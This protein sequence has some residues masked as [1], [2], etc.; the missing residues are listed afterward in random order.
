MRESYGGHIRKSLI[1][2]GVNGRLLPPSSGP[3]ILLTYVYAGGVR[4][5][6]FGGARQ[7]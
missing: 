4:A 6:F 1:L 2:R 3:A 5:E 7:G